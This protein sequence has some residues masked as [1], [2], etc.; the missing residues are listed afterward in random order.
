MKLTGL[1]AAA[2]VVALLVAVA[3]PAQGRALARARARVTSVRD[4]HQARLELQMVAM[5]FP[6]AAQAVEPAWE[7]MISN[8]R[9]ER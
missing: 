9:N 5:D 4:W 6:E 8:E 1:L 7:W 2:A 3:A